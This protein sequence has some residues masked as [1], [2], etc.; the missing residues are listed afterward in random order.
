MLQSKKFLKLI[1]YLPILVNMAV[2]VYMHIK[3][4]FVHSNYQYV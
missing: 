3:V 4:Y 1:I 2:A